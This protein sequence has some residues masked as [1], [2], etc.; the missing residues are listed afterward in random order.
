[1]I[2]QHFEQGENKIRIESAETLED[3]AKHNFE[4]GVYSRFFVNDKPVH[5]YM[6]LV[7]FMAEETKNNKNK[8]IL[9][10]KDEL[11]ALRKEM[12]LKERE[13]MK[14]QIAEMKKKYGKL[15]MAEEVI[16]MMDTMIDKVDEYGTRIVK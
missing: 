16:Q 13:E 2:T 4:K 12:I 15:G 9:K 11:M 7:Q 5:N 10:N 3:A 6:A 14:S 1:M 8:F